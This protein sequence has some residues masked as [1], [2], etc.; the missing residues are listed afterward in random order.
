[1][2]A[3]QFR[4]RSPDELSSRTLVEGSLREPFF[5]SDGQSVGFYEEIT[6][7]TGRLKTCRGAA[8]FLELYR[9]RV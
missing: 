7:G 3:T 5:S 9:H 6:A 8:L 2:R 4:V 1:M